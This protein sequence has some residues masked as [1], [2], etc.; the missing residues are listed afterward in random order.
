MPRKR[1]YDM[2]EAK[3][4]RRQRQGRGRG[5]GR[6]YI[7]GIL[8]PEFP[9]IARRHRLWSPKTQRV[10]H[11]LSDT[12]RNA[13]VVLD[14][15]D[16]VRDI[17]EQFPR[18]R[19]VTRRIANQMQVRHPTN[20]DGHDSIMTTDLLVTITTDTGPRLIAYAVKY[21]LKL[22]DRAIEK[23]EIERRVS[24]EQ[25]EQWQLVTRADIDP[26]VVRNLLSLRPYYNIAQ[27]LE[28]YAFEIPE[29]LRYLPCAYGA[30]DATTPLHAWCTELDAHF[31]WPRMTA[32]TI[33]KHLL[34]R[35]ILRT[36][37]SDPQFLE[38]RPLADFTV[39]HW[40]TTLPT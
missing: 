14:D 37:M 34:A 26:I 28:P 7:P 2:D 23:L 39:Q 5:E 33:I 1:K 17:R 22:T 27:W 6:D 21:D 24:I 16:T 29:F 3:L 38:R 32:M 31:S 10:H 19:T 18:D 11:L 8:A 13:F 40:L 30:A 25:G 15:A 4:A 36:D 12:E 35:H 20:S 9:S